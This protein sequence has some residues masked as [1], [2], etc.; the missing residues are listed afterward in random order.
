MADQPLSHAGAHAAPRRGHSR[1]RPFRLDRAD[2]NAPPALL[3]RTAQT[4]CRSLAAEE[5]RASQ[6]MAWIVWRRGSIQDGIMQAREHEAMDR[7][8]RRCRST[9]LLSRDDGDDVDH[10]F[11]T[12]ESVLAAPNMD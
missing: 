2:R 10:L 9:L 12:L 5:A 1:E 6:E 11:R 4:A 8:M 3:H 7:Q